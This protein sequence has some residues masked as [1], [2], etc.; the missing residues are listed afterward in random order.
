MYVS[1]TEV[2]AYLYSVPGPGM[3]AITVVN[4]NTGSVSNVMNLQVNDPSPRI[5][6]LVPPSAVA[7]SPDMLLHV[8]GDYVFA[9]S[10]VV[11][12]NGSARPTN[13]VSPSQIVAKIPAAD[14][15]GV[16]TANV[17]VINPNAATT[18]SN[19]VAFSIQAANPKLDFYPSSITF[20]PQVAGTSSSASAV[21]ISSS[22]NV[23][24]QISGIVLSDTANFSQTNT[25]GASVAPGSSCVLSIV[26][27]PA[28]GSPAGTQ[29]AT[30]QVNSNSSATLTIALSGAATDFALQASS[31]SVSVTA[32]HS[33]NVQLSVV[34]Y[35]GMTNLV[36]FAC[37]GLPSGST[38]SFS[39]SVVSPS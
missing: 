10:S 7:G 18:A 12:W 24:V 38:C 32:G 21:N 34:G 27:N 11:M 37:S 35:G 29:T 3:R 13:Y 25:C 23:P 1:E 19:G 2:A 30:L 20:Q 9:P 22:G 15:A 31:T 16:G 8:I 36:D 28:T 5:N 6:E 39:P 4:V 26:F 14:L 33:A 17:T